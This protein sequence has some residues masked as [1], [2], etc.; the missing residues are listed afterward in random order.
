LVLVHRVDDARPRRGGRA[1]RSTMTLHN[2]GLAEVYPSR[3]RRPRTPGGAIFLVVL[4]LTAVGLAVVMSVS[5]RIG[6]IMMGSAM[7][8]GGLA[9]L[10]IPENHAGVLRVRRKFADAAFMAGV[11][12]MILILAITIHNPS[13]T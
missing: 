5:W 9:R 13:F 12:A 4:V 3:S 7:I 1:G 8:F 11:G 10:V 2:R 6:L